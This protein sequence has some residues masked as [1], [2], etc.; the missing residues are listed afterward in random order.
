[1]KFILKFSFT[2]DPEIDMH[3]PMVI[4]GVTKRIR[5]EV[6]LIENTS[7]YIQEPSINGMLYALGV[8]ESAKI[9]VF[10][11]LRLFRNRIFAHATMRC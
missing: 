9:L 8:L 10:Y 1:M 2:C 4:C 7:S 6:C 3:H 5:E 11:A